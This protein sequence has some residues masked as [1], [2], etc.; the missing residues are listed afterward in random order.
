MS[1]RILTQQ[2][3]ADQLGRFAAMIYERTGI[4][5]SPQK[6]S[7]LS[8]R[9]RRR[10][11]A[12]GIECF[13]RYFEELRRLPPDHAEW[14]AFL[15]EITTHETYLFRDA[16]QWDWLRNSYL[17]EIQAAARRGARSPSLRIWSAACSTGD[18]VYT[19]ACCLADGLTNP[20][21]WKIEILGTDIG[22]GALQHARAATFGMRAMR[23]TPESYRR[24]F[25]SQADG[26]RW[27]AK[28]VLTQWTSFRQHNLLDALQAAPFDVVFVKNV[29]IYFDRHSKQRVFHR[30]DGALR[31]GGMLVTG[32][33]EGTSDLS[34]RYERLQPWLHRKPEVA[35]APATRRG[36][37]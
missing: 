4:R 8:N 34:H 14:D 3:N 15:Q 11:R 32:P 5:V 17:P 1:A 9:L 6:T 28:P 36:R 30:V 13:D 22:V 26:D 20:S 18:E 12:T 37:A 29:L 35:G 2:V 10:L 33:A 24:R 19:I 25:F 23:Q 21:D 16:A 31:A 27:A 7:L